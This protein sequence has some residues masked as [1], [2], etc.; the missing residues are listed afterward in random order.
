VR[1]GTWSRL[2]HNLEGLGTV[3]L[4]LR[5]DVLDH[6]LRIGLGR[7]EQH[8]YRTV[9]G[10]RTRAGNAGNLA[11]ETAAR[12]MFTSQEPTCNSTYSPIVRLFSR[13]GY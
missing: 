7:L 11:R 13:A 10:T 1:H 3:S 4:P 12:G 2:T 5:R 9:E 6:V 8:P